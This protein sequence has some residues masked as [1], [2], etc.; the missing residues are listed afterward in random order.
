ML[1][2]IAAINSACQHINFY[3]ASYRCS[4]LLSL[5][6]SFPFSL[7]LCSFPRNERGYVKKFALENISSFCSNVAFDLQLLRQLIVKNIV[8]AFYRANSRAV[9]C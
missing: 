1:N 7:F 8:N 9:R 3:L 2:L 5:P 6:L 4:V